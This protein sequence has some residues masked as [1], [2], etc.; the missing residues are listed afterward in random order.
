MITETHIIDLKKPQFYEGS[1]NFTI[2]WFNG[3]EEKFNEYHPI[4]NKF[5]WSVASAEIFVDKQTKELIQ[6][7]LLSKENIE[8]SHASKVETKNLDYWHF[9]F[10]SRDFNFDDPFQPHI[11]TFLKYYYKDIYPNNELLENALSLPL[12]SYEILNEQQIERIIYFLSV[13]QSNHPLYPLFHIYVKDGYLC[14]ISD[15]QN[16]KESK[17]ILYPI[18][19]SPQ[20][21]SLQKFSNEKNGNLHKSESVKSTEVK[22][23]LFEGFRDYEVKYI[24]DPVLELEL[25]NMAFLSRN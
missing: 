17:N 14:S 18:P 3:N 5:G 6:Y 22:S 8:L 10:F 25:K 7:R 1:L 19:E 16:P 11:D 23:I 9:E 20:S 12:V 4:D 24:S 21:Y 13:K 15:W 2:E